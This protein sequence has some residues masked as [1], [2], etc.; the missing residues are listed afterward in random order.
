MIYFVYSSMFNITFCTNEQALVEELLQK[1]KVA[2]QT[3]ES[4]DSQIKQILN[5]DGVTIIQD[6]DLPGSPPSI[7]AENSNSSDNYVGASFTLN[8]YWFEG[9]GGQKIFRTTGALGHAS[10]NSLRESGVL[11]PGFLH[12]LTYTVENLSP[13]L[14]LK[15]ERFKVDLILE[16]T[17]LGP[18]PLPK[19]VPTP[20]SPR[21]GH[22]GGSLFREMWQPRPLDERIAHIPY[23]VNS[24]QRR[25]MGGEL[26]KNFWKRNT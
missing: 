3:V 19:V 5:N 25:G 17:N 8:G 10:L 26:L 14:R 22:L 15:F 2:S 16:P 9:P 1:R 11:P 23:D 6:N 13:E 7:S 18:T 4:L 21:L 20:E 24:P 12:D